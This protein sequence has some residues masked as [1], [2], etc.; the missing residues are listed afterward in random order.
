MLF[1]FELR[2]TLLEKR[3]R[4]LFHVVGAARQ[5]KE[6]RLQLETVRKGPVP[7]LENGLK[8]VLESQGTAAQEGSGHQEEAEARLRIKYRD[9]R[10]QELQRYIAEQPDMFQKLVQQRTA[11]NLEELKDY[12][13]LP[14]QTKQQ[15][16]ASSAEWTIRSAIADR[17]CL[18]FEEWKRAQANSSQLSAEQTPQR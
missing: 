17:I 11:H 12:K 4:P 5:A 18:S 2:G 3:L 6:I 9:Y 8:G 10:E 7:S 15:S 1:P 14:E 16:A 13:K